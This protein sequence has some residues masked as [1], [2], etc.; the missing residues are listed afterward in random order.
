MYTYYMLRF[1]D[2]TQWEAVKTKF[3]LLTLEGV[4]VDVIDLLWYEE[5]Y[6][7]NKSTSFHV[8]IAVDGERLPERLMPFVVKPAFIK[9]TFNGSGLHE[10]IDKTDY[11]RTP[12]AKILGFDVTERQLD[13]LKDEP[14]IIKERSLEAV[15][16]KEVRK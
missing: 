3:K 2:K 4:F 5:T 1:K 14:V 10:L 6:K 16:I 8:N 7:G 13:E 9:R 12:E 15:I 11:E